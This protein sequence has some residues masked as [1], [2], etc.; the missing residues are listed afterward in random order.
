[1]EKSK[2][3]VTLT[4]D[5]RLFLEA[6]IHHGKTSA[7]MIRHAYIL[8]HADKLDTDFDVRLHRFGDEG[9]VAGL[10]FVAVDRGGGNKEY[11]V[12]KVA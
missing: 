4:D 5:Q 8:L 11:T 2:Y 9:E 7:S 12:R 10:S 6:L 1:M 3:T